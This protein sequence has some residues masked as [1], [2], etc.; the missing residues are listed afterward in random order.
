[1]LHA[2]VVP[3]CGLAIGATHFWGVAERAE[4]DWERGGAVWGCFTTALTWV[5]A[6]HEASVLAALGSSLH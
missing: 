4:A 2:V 6:L 5:G 1:M 3:F